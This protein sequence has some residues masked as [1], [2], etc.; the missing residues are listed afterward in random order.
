[1]K[2]ILKAAALAIAL[3][4]TAVS[5]NAQQK[6]DMAAGINLGYAATDGYN[7][8][9]L[10]AKFQYNVIDPLRLEARFDYFFPNDNLGIKTNYWD[11]M[12]DAHW[13]FPVG[14]MVNLYPLAG[15][16]VL[17]AK[18]RADVM[19]VGARKNTGSTFAFNLG[20]GADLFLSDTIFLNA[21]LRYMVNDGG[22]F[23]P[24]VGIGY[25]F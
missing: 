9:G 6:G 8:L 1:M 7:N 3:V 22:Y 17:G 14:R 21:Q 10:G 2:N 12:I 5:A 11:F 20:G 15:L 16:G 24:S 23:M 4:L 19:G 25:A 18:V 13:I